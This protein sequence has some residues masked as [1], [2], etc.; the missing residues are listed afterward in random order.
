MTTRTIPQHQSDPFKGLSKAA[1]KKKRHALELKKEEE[2]FNRE[3]FRLLFDELHSQIFNSTVQHAENALLH[4]HP[5]PCRE[6]INKFETYQFIQ[7]LRKDLTEP[8][9]D[10]QLE[11]E[12]QPSKDSNL[13]L[14]DLVKA[15][16]PESQQILKDKN[17]QL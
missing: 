4:G 7:L 3:T 16:S 8:G 15:L 12:W 10:L 6:I 11:D 2:Y 5:N 9:T 14:A 13:T 17:I 1:L